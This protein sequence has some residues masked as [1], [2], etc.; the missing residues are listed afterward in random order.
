M[1]PYC[2]STFARP[3]SYSLAKYA[4][5]ALRIDAYSGGTDIQSQSNYLPLSPINISNLPR[6]SHSRQI[7]ADPLPFQL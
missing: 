6:S 3:R 4:P 5:A 1:L 2:H 7:L